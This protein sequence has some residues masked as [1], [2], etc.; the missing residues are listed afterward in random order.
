MVKEAEVSQKKW[1]TS[2]RL[3]HIVGNLPTMSV[4]SHEHR[5][6]FRD[7]LPCREILSHLPAQHA[8]A[9]IAS[10]GAQ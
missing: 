7:L 6:V 4:K 2:P 5:R 1:L 3:C 8:F 10:T 9:A